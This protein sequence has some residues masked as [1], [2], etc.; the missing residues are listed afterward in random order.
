MR[1]TTKAS[2]M[3]WVTP[4]AGVAGGLIYLIA[5]SLGGQPVTG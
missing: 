4:A 3:Y 2:R 5:F 1:I